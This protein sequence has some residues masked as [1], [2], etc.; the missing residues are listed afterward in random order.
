MPSTP[1]KAET[2]AKANSKTGSKDSPSEILKVGSH[3]HVSHLKKNGIISEVMSKARYRVCVGSLAMTCS[4][5]QLSASKATQALQSKSSKIVLPKVTAPPTTLDLHGCTVD[6]AIRKLELWLDR[7]V[8]AGLSRLKVIH[9]FGSG[10]VQ[11]AIHQ[12]LSQLTAVANFKINQFN[13]GETDI[14][15]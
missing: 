8:L 5:D 13:A 1:K 6:D 7:A 11:K 3:V 15:L 12:R 14:F 9:G 10:K 4:A 2:M